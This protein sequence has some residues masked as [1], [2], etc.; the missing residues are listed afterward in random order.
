MQTTRQLCVCL[1]HLSTKTGCNMSME[2]R[3][4][5]Q[6]KMITSRLRLLA[7]FISVLIMA[8]NREQGLDITRDNSQ[9][10]A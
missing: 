10:V 7:H 8:S 3:T 5:S 4:K 6:M 9:Y 2:R 1:S